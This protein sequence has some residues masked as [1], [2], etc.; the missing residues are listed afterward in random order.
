MERAEPQLIQRR[1]YDFELLYVVKGELQAEVG[2]KSLTVLPGSLLYLPSLLPHR[3]I[4]RE[5]ASLIGIHYDYFGELSLT[6][7]EEII[8]DEGNVRQSRFCREPD[9]AIIGGLQSR[10]VLPVDSQC[11]RLMEQI[12][13][14]FHVR[15][16]G[17][18]LACRGLLLQL[19]AHLLR[20]PDKPVRLQPHARK[21]ERAIARIVR[22]I[23]A[24]CAEEWSRARLGRELNVHEDY[25]CRLFKEITGQSWSKY[26]QQVR[27]QEAKRLLRM[28]EL[29]VEMVGRQVGYE[30]QHYFNRIF[31]KWEGVSPGNY[32]R[33]AETL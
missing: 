20:T 6:G 30:D 19:F 32:R 10:H 17:Y 23:E 24:C 2:E 12:V 18:E 4:L 5:E 3:L 14:E 11:V 15:S 22:S 29:K 9:Y 7:D 1:L 25:A 28:S 13:K 8:V 16:E 33:M 21:Y 26:V 27:H 31:T